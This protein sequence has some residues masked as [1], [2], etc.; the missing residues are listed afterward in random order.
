[1]LILLHLKAIYLICTILL[2]DTLYLRFNICFEKKTKTIRS[3]DTLYTYCDLS[4]IET[5]VTWSYWPA[6]PEPDQNVY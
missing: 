6:R 5:D 2:W 1:M 4:L 3:S